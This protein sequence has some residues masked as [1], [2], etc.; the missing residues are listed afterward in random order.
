MKDVVKTPKAKVVENLMH[1]DLDKPSS[2]HF[3]LTGSQLTEWERIELIEFLIV[4]IE[5]FAWTPYKM[6]KIYPSFVKH[7][8]NVILEARLVKQRRWRFATKHVDV[9]IE[10]VEK[11]KEASAINEVLYPSC[12]S[13]IVVIDQLLDSTSGQAR[14]SFLNAY[15]GG[16]LSRISASTEPTPESPEVH[17]KPP[18][19]TKESTTKEIT[20]VVRFTGTTSDQSFYSV[21]NVH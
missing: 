21:E 20:E 6:P 15:Q 9:V 14:M 16:E 5:V 2:D 12:L 18:Q 4:N 13:I 19:G 7:E 10:E 11:L 1:Y 3:F 8:L 17:K